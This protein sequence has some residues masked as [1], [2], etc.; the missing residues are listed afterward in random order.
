MTA[1]ADIFDFHQSTMIILI[2]NVGF[3][4][5]YGLAIVWIAARAKS[6][7]RTALQSA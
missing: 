5:A 3:I 7:G 6:S 2:L 1:Y 4:A